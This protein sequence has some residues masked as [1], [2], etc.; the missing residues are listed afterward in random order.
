[1][2]LWNNAWVYR[3][4]TIGQTREGVHNVKDT[5]EGVDHSAGK[6]FSKEDKLNYPKEKVKSGAA[7]VPY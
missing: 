2:Y 6:I 7:Y 4:L 3:E 5:R 1:M